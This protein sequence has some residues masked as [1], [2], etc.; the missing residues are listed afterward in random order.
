MELKL[1]IDDETGS[2]KSIMV[3]SKLEI[4]IIPACGQDRDDIS[5]VTL[6]FLR[7]SYKIRLLRIISSRFLLSK[8]VSL[9]SWT[10]KTQ[11]L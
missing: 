8:L 6:M 10:P 4:P 3:A 2:G 1:I 5:T 11:I 9:D 7:S